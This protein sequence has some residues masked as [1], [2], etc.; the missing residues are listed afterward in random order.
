MLGEEG[1]ELLDDTEPAFEAVRALKSPDIGGRVRRGEVLLV[2]E[3]EG[4]YLERSGG[5]EPFLSGSPRDKGLD[6]G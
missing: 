4:P 2:G 1:P 5:D 3:A 6:L